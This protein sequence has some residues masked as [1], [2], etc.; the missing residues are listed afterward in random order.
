PSQLRRQDK[1]VVGGGL[2]GSSLNGRES[3][4]GAG[5]AEERNRHD[6]EAAVFVHRLSRL[7]Q[8][9]EQGGRTM[10]TDTKTESTARECAAGGGFGGWYRRPD[11]PLVWISYFDRH[12]RRHRESSGSPF[13]RVALRLLK[14]RQREL[15][16]NG[17]VVGPRV[18]GT[19]FD[20]LEKA[21]VRYFDAN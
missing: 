19:R 15:D 13:V 16:D 8:P 20:D 11:S 4:A 18:E 17:R 2:R 21:L 3:A 7:R 12:G 6:V 14:Q 9:R 10:R 1:R 5:R